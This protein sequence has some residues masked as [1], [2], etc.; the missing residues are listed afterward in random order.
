MKKRVHAYFSGQVQGVF[1]RATIQKQAQKLGITGWVKNLK[2]GR[3]ELIVEGEEEMLKNAIEF[4]KKYTKIT[5]EEISWEKFK[6]E[7]VE[8]KILN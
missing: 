7:F 4:C 2:D 5:A 3:V 8:F 6:G 1:L